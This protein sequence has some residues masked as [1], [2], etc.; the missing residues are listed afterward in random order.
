MHAEKI[1][2]VEGGTTLRVLYT[3]VCEAQV[4]L[5]GVFILHNFQVYY[6]IS[7]III[8]SKNRIQYWIPS[9][10]LIMLLA[11]SS[12]LEKPLN[13]NAICAIHQILSV[14][15][16]TAYAHVALECQNDIHR[17]DYYST[18]GNDYC[19]HTRAHSAHSKPRASICDIASM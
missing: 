9:P 17:F 7:D 3:S 13:A 16:V 1:W 19:T 4:C 11:R 6:H 12:S 8:Q 2:E 10:A 14:R 18:N 5:L 15:W